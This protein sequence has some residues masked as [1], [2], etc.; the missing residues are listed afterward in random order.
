M[1]KRKKNPLEWKDD[2]P[3]VVAGIVGV[4]VAVEVVVAVVIAVAAVVGSV[5]VPINFQLALQNIL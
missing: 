2:S 4:V 3:A 1:T 5:V